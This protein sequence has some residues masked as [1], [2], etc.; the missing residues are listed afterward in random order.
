ML[1]FKSKNTKYLYRVEDEKVYLWWGF[2][3]NR[4]PDTCWNS[5]KRSWDKQAW[6]TLKVLTEDRRFIHV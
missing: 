3:Q 1:K 6:P 5:N 4:D 2:T